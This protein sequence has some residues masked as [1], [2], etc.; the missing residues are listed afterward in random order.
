MKMKTLIT[1][2]SLSAVLAMP[3][4]AADK[5]LMVLSSHG[6]LNEEGQLQ[7]P[8]FEFDEM[9]KAYLVLKNH[10]IEVDFA[11]PKGGAPVADKYDQSKAYNQAFTADNQATHK[12]ADTLK[13]ADIRAKDYRGVFV[14][15]GKGPMF[16]LHQDADLQKTIGQIYETDGVIA[17]VCHGPAALVDVKLSDG[18][19]LLE[20]KK[21]S[22]FTNEEEM[23][24]GKKWRPEFAFL[25]EDKLKER[26]AEFIAAPMMLHQV[27][28][29]GRLITGQNPFS[30]ADAA[31][32][33]VK[34]MGIQ[35]K[36]HKDW[37]DDA[38][39][40]LIARL[41]EGDEAAKTQLEAHQQDYQIELI[42]MYGYYQLMLAQETKAKR[43][44]IELM[45]LAAPAMAEP[46]LEMAIAQGYQQIGEQKM[47]NNALN[48]LLKK[49]PEHED[50][51]ALLTQWQ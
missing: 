33:M 50:A 27:S 30:T 6:E 19:Y 26:G 41:L 12:L 46:Q 36:P 14:V 9:A 40:K 7:R 5:V 1:C 29:D 51:K 45:E 2:L 15:G 49:W 20:G 37:Q 48:N 8:G 38:T 17:A 31:I 10:D 47:A 4:F 16:D 35:P 18:R 11:S 13:L 34:A 44:A 22:G 39:V 32:E 23:A 43:V 3:T 42:G 21:V 25:L 28:V 24:F